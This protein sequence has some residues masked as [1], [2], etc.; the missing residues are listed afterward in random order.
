MKGHAVLTV[1]S[2]SEQRINQLRKFMDPEIDVALEKYA[3]L[4]G[5]MNRD[6]PSYYSAARFNVAVEILNDGK[7]WET[8]KRA[9]LF[10]ND[11]ERLYYDPC[12]CR[13]H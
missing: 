1:N 12:R 11:A 3:E 4:L 6:I 5:R 13:Y 10:L 8:G 7:P 9:Q 2:L